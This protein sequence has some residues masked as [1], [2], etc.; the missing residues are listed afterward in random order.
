MRENTNTNTS[1]N[2][3]NKTRNAITLERKHT[4]GKPRQRQNRV[5]EG[6]V[7]E[8]GDRYEEEQDEEGEEQEEE[9]NGMN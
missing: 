7:T 2:T 6:H 9:K 4:T 3:N 1:T 5:E 8:G